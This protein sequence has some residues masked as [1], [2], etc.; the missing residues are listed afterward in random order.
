MRVIII[1]II[2]TTTTTITIIFIFKW[3]TIFS[4]YFRIMCVHYFKESIRGGIAN[5]YGFPIKYLM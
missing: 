2:T 1:I 5:F 4:N 3:V